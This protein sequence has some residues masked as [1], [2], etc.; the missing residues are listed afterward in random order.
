MPLGHDCVYAASLIILEKGLFCWPSHIKQHYCV[1]MPLKLLCTY[2]DKHIQAHIK[3]PIS[4]CTTFD[5][6]H[7]SQCKAVNIF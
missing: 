1:P 3:M 4:A 5:V 6:F 2:I 7:A